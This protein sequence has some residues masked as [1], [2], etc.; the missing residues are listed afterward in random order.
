[1]I[2]DLSICGTEFFNRLFYGAFLEIMSLSGSIIVAFLIGMTMVVSGLGY[3]I[4]GMGNAQPIQC[5]FALSVAGTLYFGVLGVIHGEQI[6]WLAAL[7]SAVMGF[8]QYAGVR[9]MRTALQMGPFS[10]VWC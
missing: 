1:M 10:P 9:L 7:I 3:K 8:T 5:A 2:P 6:G 4:G